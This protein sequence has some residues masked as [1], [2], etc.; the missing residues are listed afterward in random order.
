LETL[1][2]NRPAMFDDITPET[3]D[4]HAWVYATRANVIQDITESQTGDAFASY[5]FPKLFLDSN[6]NVVYT[7]GT[8]EVFHR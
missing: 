2:G 6:F 3:T 7:N 5:G 1:V 8:S 4:A